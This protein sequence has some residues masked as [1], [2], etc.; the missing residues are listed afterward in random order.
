VLTLAF[1]A[2]NNLNAKGCKV[3]G[4]NNFCIT[5]GKNNK[6]AN[7]AVIGPWAATGLKARRGN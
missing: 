1:F 6:Q 5:N 4:W 3:A 7:G 2:G